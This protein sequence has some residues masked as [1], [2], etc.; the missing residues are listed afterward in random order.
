ML[1]EL[2][3]A[4]ITCEKLSYA[5]KRTYDLRLAMLGR[6][7]KMEV[8]CRANGFATIYKWLTGVDLLVLRRDRSEALVVMPMSTLIEL[9]KSC[10][11]PL[12]TA[13]KRD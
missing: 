1:H 11:V 4:G 7:A 12:K 9:V 8:K 3:D 2:Q 5:W 13:R 6:H 10:S